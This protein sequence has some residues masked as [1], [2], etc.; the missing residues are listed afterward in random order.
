MTTDSDPVV[1]SSYIFRNIIKQHL[2]WMTGVNKAYFPELAHNFT[3]FRPGVF[4]NTYLYALAPAMAFAEVQ[5]KRLRYTPQRGLPN[6]ATMTDVQITCLIE[7]VLVYG[8]TGDRRVIPTRLARTLGLVP[9]IFEGCLPSF[10][11]ILK[12]TGPKTPSMSAQDWP[13]FNG[14]PLIISGP[15]VRFHYGPVWEQVSLFIPEFFS[16][17]PHEGGVGFCFLFSG[18]APPGSQHRRLPILPNLSKIS[19]KKTF[20]SCTPC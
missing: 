6:G 19:H 10:S 2:Q 8:L 7:R 16:S 20:L 13:Q 14:E 9:A 4:P 11:A 5:W 18:E 17:C 1:P 3:I 12:L 15:T